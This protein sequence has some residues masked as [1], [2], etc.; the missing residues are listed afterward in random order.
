MEIPLGFEMP[1]KHKIVEKPPK[2]EAIIQHQTRFCPR[3]EQQKEP[4]KEELNSSAKE[5]ELEVAMEVESEESDVELDMEG[6]IGEYQI[7][8]MDLSCTILYYCFQENPMKPSPTTRR[9]LKLTWSRARPASPSTTCPRLPTRT[10]FRRSRSP[11][12]AGSVTSTCIGRATSVLT[13]GWPVIRS[14]WRHCTCCV[15]R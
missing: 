9:R 15:A 10:S 2:A 1:S 8:M 5:Q 12:S 6:V 7:E 4:Q 13:V 3:P 11:V 14:V